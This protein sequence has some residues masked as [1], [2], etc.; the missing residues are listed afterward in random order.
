[1]V[2]TRDT[3]PGRSRHTPRL[4]IRRHPRFRGA[5]TADVSLSEVVPVALPTR[6]IDTPANSPPARDNLNL[7]IPSA[8]NAYSCGS[9]KP[10]SSNRGRWPIRLSY[11]FDRP[12][13]ILTGR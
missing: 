5:T 11:T 3:A 12:K 8:S 13:A 6:C 4:K 1:P 10:P 9:P 2:D 7:H